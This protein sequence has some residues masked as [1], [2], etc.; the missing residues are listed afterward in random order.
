MSA[1]F[2]IVDNILC[3]VDNYRDERS[4]R[5]VIPEPLGVRILRQFHEDLPAGHVGRYKMF[6]HVQRLTPFTG[7]FVPLFLDTISGEQIFEACAAGL[8]PPIA[9]CLAS[10]VSLN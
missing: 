10:P 9:R 8:S 3:F 4:L 7:K 1:R 6:V 5:I 2:M